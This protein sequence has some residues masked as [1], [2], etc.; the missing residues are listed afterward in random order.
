[1]TRG[2][3]EIEFQGIEFQG[4]EDGQNWQAYPFR[5]QPRFDGNL[6]FASP[7]WWREYPIVPNT[8]VRLLG[9]DPEALSLF[10]GNPFSRDPPCQVRAVLWQYWFTTMAEKRATG[11]WSRRQ[12]LGLYAPTLVHGPDGRIQV[13]QWPG[14]APRQ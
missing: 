5:Y 11:R 8:Q 6:W 2:R 1:M 9:N 10:A 14:V 7:R 3:N 4:S 13:A 12:F